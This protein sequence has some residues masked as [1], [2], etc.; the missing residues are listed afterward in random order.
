MKYQRFESNQGISKRTKKWLTAI[1]ATGAFAS[2]SFMFAPNHS[3]ESTASAATSSK[4]ADHK[5]ATKG[6]KPKGAPKGKKGAKPPMGKMNAKHSS[7]K[8]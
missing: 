4:K 7:S 3:P 5:P 6:D 2:L 8:K 1:V